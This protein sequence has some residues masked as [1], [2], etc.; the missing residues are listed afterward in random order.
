MTSLYYNLDR[1][2]EISPA[3]LI[4]FD[5]NLMGIIFSILVPRLLKRK[6]FYLKKGIN[7]AFNEPHILNS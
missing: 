2:F 5:C 1:K 6:V 4:Y 3:F 7:T